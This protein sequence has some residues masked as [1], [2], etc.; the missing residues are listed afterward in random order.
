MS[1]ILYAEDE[2][3]VREVTTLT[4]EMVGGFTVLACNDGLDLLEQVKPFA[5]DLILLDVMMPRLDGPNTLERLHADPTTA[6]IPV[7]FLTAKI[8]QEELD[9]YKAIGAI[10]VISKPFDPMTLVDQI[11]QLWRPTQ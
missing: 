9:H 2:A 4:L 6:A 10:G 1:K 7:I 11:K 3:D 8:M 5:P